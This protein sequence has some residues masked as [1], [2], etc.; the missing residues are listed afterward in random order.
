MTYPSVTIYTTKKAVRIKEKRDGI[1]YDTDGNEVDTSKLGANQWR[2]IAGEGMYDVT[3][4][5]RLSHAEVM[6]S[7]NRALEHIK[8]NPKLWEQFKKN[9]FS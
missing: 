9:Q 4:P 2:A 6:E 1:V 5:L 8:N 7:R 3:S